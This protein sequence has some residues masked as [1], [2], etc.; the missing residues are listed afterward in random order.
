M[1]NSQNTSNKMPFDSE[2]QLS[3]LKDDIQDYII[4]AEQTL[5]D[6]DLHDISYH[7]FAVDVALGNLFSLIAQKYEQNLKSNA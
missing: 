7:V 5:D 1:Y 6:G 2:S 4:W 3:N